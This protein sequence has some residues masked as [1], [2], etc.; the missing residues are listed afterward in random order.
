MSGSSLDSDNQVKDKLN[1][2][3]GDKSISNLENKIKQVKSKNPL[4]DLVLEKSEN[5]S[6]NNEI[7]IPIEE[8][9]DEF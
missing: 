7:E 5:S 3:F 2:S 6:E 1:I 8:D 4:E 9:V